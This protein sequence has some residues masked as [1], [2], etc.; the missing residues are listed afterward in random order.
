MVGIVEGV[1]VCVVLCSVGGIV[2][3]VIEV[4]IVAFFVTIFDVI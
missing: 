3:D 1:G 2:V 4:V